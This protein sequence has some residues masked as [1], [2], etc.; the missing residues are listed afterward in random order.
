MA[1]PANTA[2]ALDPTRRLA[3]KVMPFIAADSALL[4]TDKWIIATLRDMYKTVPVFQRALRT[5]GLVA[6]V[7]VGGLVLAGGGVA[8]LAMTGALTVTAALG[9]GVMCAATSMYAFWRGK[10]LWARAQA[11][12]LP[13]LKEEIGKRYA[14]Y[15]MDEIGAAFRQRLEASRAAKA[16]GEAPAAKAPTKS[17]REIFARKPA[18][19]DQAAP[20]AKAAAPKAPPKP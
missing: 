19:G 15:K 9:A 4:P 5:A 13:V 8:A 12:T 16:A 10:N 7:G 18:N 6:A 2:A 1:Q 3:R 14:K 11:E 20:A 17:L